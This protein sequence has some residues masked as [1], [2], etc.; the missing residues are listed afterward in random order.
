MAL[1]IVFILCDG[2]DHAGLSIL[3]QL[4]SF[5]KKGLGHSWDS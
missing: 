5:L 1:L 3:V 4:D 2:V